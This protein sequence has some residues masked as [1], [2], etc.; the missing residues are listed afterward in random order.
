[1]KQKPCYILGIESSCDDTAASILNHNKVLSNCITNQK[2]H[3]EYGGVVPELA[4]RAHQSNIVPVVD[5][6][7]KKA[8]I[9][10][11]D[12]SAIAFTQGPGLLGS[13]LVGGSFAKSMSLGLNIPLIAVHHMQAHLLVHFIKSKEIIP[14]SFPFIGVNI[15]GGHTQIILVNDYFKM[16]VI[17]STIDD[18]IGE[19]FDKCGKLIGLKYPAGPEIDRLSQNGNS[20]RFEFPIPKVNN[21]NVSYSGVKTAFMNF[22]IKEKQNNLKF[23]QE[24][25]NDICASIQKILI[26]IIFQKINLAV[27]ETGIKTV[28]IGGGVSANSEL[29]KLLKNQTEINKWNVHIPPIEYTTDNGAMIGIAGYYKWRENNFTSL[30]TPSQA[31]IDF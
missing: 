30:S 5:F 10:C 16:K 22:I 7:L 19:A 15:S 13:L 9:Q 18:A 8:K 28:A 27:K 24:N 6:A 4:S 29:R 23:V 25:I 31:R 11:K 20:Y 1:M 14:P 12:L 3:T 17:G 21:L 2:I 26:K